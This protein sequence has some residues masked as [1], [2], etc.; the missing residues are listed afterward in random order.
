MYP[1]TYVFKSIYDQI[2]SKF[3]CCYISTQ[4]V[5]AFVNERPSVFDEN[6]LKCTYWYT[7]NVRVHLQ[8]HLVLHLFAM[9][10]I[11]HVLGKI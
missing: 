11:F 6:T 2:K 10:T 3:R 8:P 5:N 7:R 9:T 1:Q 4:S